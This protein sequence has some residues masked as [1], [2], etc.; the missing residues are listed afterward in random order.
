MVLLLGLTVGAMEVGDARCT[1]LPRHCS[2][3]CLPLAAH[4]LEAL[5]HETQYLI[6]P[7]FRKSLLKGDNRVQHVLR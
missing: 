7:S 2:S 6:S 1:P 5:G 3:T 4:T